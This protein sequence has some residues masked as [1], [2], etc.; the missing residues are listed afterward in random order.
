MKKTLLCLALALLLVCLAGCEARELPRDA[1]AA[2][3]DDLRTGKNE[4][5][6]ETVI[7]PEAILPLLDPDSPQPLTRR[8]T[9][10][11][12][13][14]LAYQIRDMRGTYD[15]TLVEITLENRDLAAA[16]EAYTTALTAA[17]AEG[18]TLPD[19]ERAALFETACGE[20]EQINSRE[21]VL[22]MNFD[23]RANCWK[24]TVPEDFWDAALGG[25]PAL[26]AELS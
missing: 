2:L 5:L 7:S 8:F 23:S 14:G 25:D 15:A 13:G 6:A 3:I 24:F 12:L 9:R 22:T 4:S 26:L 17:E 16:V 21:L 11:A 20:T 1:V 18:Q 19:A 10:T